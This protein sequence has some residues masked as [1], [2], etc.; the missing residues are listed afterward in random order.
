M[1]P[2]DPDTLYVIGKTMFS[3]DQ[4]SRGKWQARALVGSSTMSPFCNT[5]EEA[6]GYIRRGGAR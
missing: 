4:D 3:V 5:Q 6:V 2:L 1:A